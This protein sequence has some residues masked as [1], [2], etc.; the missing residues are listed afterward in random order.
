MNKKIVCI[1]ISNDLINGKPNLNEISQQYYA[2]LYNKKH[3]DGYYKS[4]HF[5]EIPNWISIINYNVDCDFYIC[6][7]IEETVNYLL[8][9]NY[10]YVCFS[11]LDVN[12]HIIKDIID[13]YNYE[14]EEYNFYN[15]VNEASKF[16]LGGYID[17]FEYFKVC[18]SSSYIIFNTIKEFINYLGIEYK[19]GY[20]YKHFKDYETIPRLTLSTGC[21]HNCDF[22]TIEKELKEIPINTILQQI[23]SFEPLKFKLV[24]IN[25]KTYGQCQNYKILPNIYRLIKKYNKQFKGFIIQTTTTKFLTFE[26]KFIKDA[27]IKYIELGIETYNDLILKKYHKPS[28]EKTINLSCDKIRQLK[29]VWLIPNILIGIPEE[30]ELSYNR[31][32]KFIS[33]NKDIISHMNIYNLAVYDN[34][35]LSKKL[36]YTEADKNENNL[37]KSFHKD[38]TIHNNFYVNIHILGI[39]ILIYGNKTNEEILNNETMKELTGLTDSEYNKQCSKKE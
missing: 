21:L 12:K 23:K 6:K 19:L 26:N 10:N 1:Q 8:V 18:D 35:P 34:T 4:Y 28:S 24:Y 27:H 38:K 37:N 11:V 2:T 15:C 13:N 3:S 9:N 39:D 25:D 30:T 20:D 36:K 5:W 16:I 31:T 33:Q 7:N 22:C 29:N 17:L 32:L 14:I